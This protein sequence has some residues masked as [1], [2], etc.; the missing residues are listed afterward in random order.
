MKPSVFCLDENYTDFIRR[1]KPCRWLSLSQGVRLLHGMWMFITTSRRLNARARAIGYK[2]VTG[3]CSRAHT[4]VQQ[5]IWKCPESPWQQSVIKSYF[6]WW[7]IKNGI[8]RNIRHLMRDNTGRWLPNT[9]ILH[10]HIFRDLFFPL[11]LAASDKVRNQSRASLTLRFKAGASQRQSFKPMR[12]ESCHLRN[13][14]RSPKSTQIK[15]GN[16]EN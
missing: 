8:C 13:G 1:L 14:K 2:T 9:S 15:L 5:Y 4:P 7:Q 16:T 12:Q 11:L 10:V 3:T 6:L